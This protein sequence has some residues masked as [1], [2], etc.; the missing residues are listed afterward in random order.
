MLLFIK[1]FNDLNIL[2]F[3]FAPHQFDMRWKRNQLYKNMNNM[4][5][6]LHIMSKYE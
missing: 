2:F 6:I 3:E 4:N 1:I 5:T